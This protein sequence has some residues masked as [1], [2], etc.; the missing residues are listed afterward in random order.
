MISAIILAAGRSTR[1]GRPKPL[2]TYGG[3]PFVARI[4]DTLFQGGA[5]EVV[6]VLG[7]YLFDVERAV[8]KDPRIKIAVNPDYHQG[9]VLSLQCGIRS[10]GAASRALLGMPVDCPGVRPETVGRLVAAFEAEGWPIILPTFQGRRG[11]PTL[12]ARAVYDE[13]L[14]AP[15]DR[16]ARVIVRKDPAR[17]REVPVEDPGILLDI[18]TPEDYAALQGEEKR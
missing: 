1:M 8:P 4:C 15:L 2:L 16:G 17:V 11:H 7:A 14:S 10:L 13:L 18:D 9:Q 5:G 12:F 3:R 6:V